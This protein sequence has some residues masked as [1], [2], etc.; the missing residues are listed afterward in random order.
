MVL[1]IIF[2]F[3]KQTKTLK[4]ISWL[5]HQ[6]ITIFKI[7]HW[8]LGRWKHQD[9]MKETY[10]ADTDVNLLPYHKWVKWPQSWANMSKYHYMFSPENSN[11]WM[12]QI[13]DHTNTGFPQTWI[14]LNLF[15]WWNSLQ[16]NHDCHSQ[17][18][19]QCCWE[20]LFLS[21]SHI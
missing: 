3:K 11:N 9:I 16:I 10:W 21:L 2:S 18:A 12:P 15:C 19:S 5:L 6:Q 13:F 7:K 8:S 20:I 14:F 4:L 1:P 17:Q